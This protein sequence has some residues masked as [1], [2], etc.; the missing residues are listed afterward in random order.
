MEEE[1][2]RDGAQHNSTLGF[3]MIQLHC[4]SRQHVDFQSCSLHPINWT[5]I[6][7]QVASMVAQLVKNLPAVWD[8]WVRSLGWKDPLEKEWLPTPGL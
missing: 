1:R 8:T 6:E 5:C 7:V 4:G 3:E 2:E